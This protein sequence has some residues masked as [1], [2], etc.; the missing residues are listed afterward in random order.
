[1]SPPEPTITINGQ[2]LNEAQ[3]M[4]ARVAVSCFISQLLEPP[5]AEALGEDLAAGYLARAREVE[6]MLVRRRR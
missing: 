4:T 3:A 5:F 1:M 2:V 6:D